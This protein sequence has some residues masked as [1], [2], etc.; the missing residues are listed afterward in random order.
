MPPRTPKACRCRG[1]RNTTTDSSGFCDAHKGENWKNY[2]PGQNRH[3]RGY[4]S[5]W[6]AIKKRI[7]KRDNGLCQLCLQRG[8]IT[9]ATCVDHITPIAH[10]GGDSADNLQ[11][12]CAPCHRA[13][14]ARE[15][16]TGR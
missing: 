5:H 11:S 10:G 4:G 13:K 12:L 16:R 1:C 14:T 2:K 8:A 15:R 7:L 9:A 6:D 3:Q